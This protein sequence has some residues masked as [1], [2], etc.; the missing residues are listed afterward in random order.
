MTPYT[1]IASRA[2]LFLL[3]AASS[4]ALTTN[5]AAAQTKDDQ[6]A[7]M[8]LNSAH[9]AFNEKN[10]SFAATRFREFLSRYGGR[11][12]A[13]SARYGLALALLDSPERKFDE[14]RN[15]L[16]G[17][18]NDNN[19]P[20]RHLARYYLAVAVRSQGLH[21]LN[22]GEARPNEM[23]QRRA[24]AQ[25]RF[26]EA[27]PLFTAALTGF[28]D[29]AKNEKVEGK[30]LPVAVEWTARAR[31]DLAEMQVRLNRAKD[32][33][34]TAEPFVKDAVASR[35]RYRDLGR[36][37]HGYA[38]LLLKDYPA[39]EKSLTLLAPFRPSSFASHARY[40]LA[41]TYHLQDERT[42]ALALYD[43][44]VNEYQKSKDE[45]VKRL[46]QPNALKDNPA[47]RFRLEALVRNPPPEYVGRSQF[48]LGVLQ[49]EA[50]KFA[51]ARARFQEML[52]QHPQ[53]PLRTEAELR[54]GFCQV[55]QK[56]YAEAQKTLQPLIDRD[57]RLSDQVLFWLARAQAGAAPDEVVNAAGHRQAI[58]NAM[59]TLRQA[60]DRAQRIESQDP[61]ARA[62][63]AEIMFELADQMQAVKQHREA[64]NLYGQLQNDKAL[65]DR[66]EELAQ[67]Q[68]AALHLA[69][70]H[71]ASDQACERFFKQF[72]Q[73]TLTPAVQFTYGENSFF[74]IAEAEKIGNADERTKQIA[75]RAKETI[76]RFE[77]LIT[78]YPEDPRVHIARYSVGLTYYR[79][80]DLEHA[81][82]Y[83]AEIPDAERAGTLRLVPYLLADCTLR[84]VPTSIP[85]DALGAGKMEEQLKSAATLLGA[86]I[87]AQPKAAETPDALLKL[88]LT[89]QRLAALLAQPPDKAKALTEARTTYE[90]ITR[91]YGSHPSAAQAVLERAKCIAQ[92]GDINQ[93]TNELRRF[94][95][96][97]LR[98]APVAPIALIQLATYLRMQ[99]RA[100][101][102]AELMGKTRVQYEGRLAGVPEYAHWVPLMHYHYGICQQ[103][104]GK[105]PEA[106]AAFRLVVNRTKG[107]P[108][109]TEAAL[110]YGQCLKVEGQQ[111]LEKANK[112]RSSGKKE[113]RAQASGF[114]D[115]GTRQLREATT[116]LEGQAA[117]LKG[118]EGR[119]DVR[120]RMLYEA[121][122]ASRM[123]GEMEMK[124]ERAK[125]AQELAKK[126][127]PAAAKFPLPP[128]PRAKVPVQPA[129]K[130]ALDLYNMLVGEFGEQ[131]IATEARFE[132]AE[133]LAQR[134]GHEPALKLL[135][136]VLDKE[137]SPEL[138]EKV[139]LRLGAVHAASGDLKAALAQFDAVAA[140][141]KSP[142][143][144]WAQYRAGE[145]LL[146]AE[147]PAEAIKRLQP[148]RDGPLQ[149]VPGVTDRALLRLGQAYAAL[150]NWDAS[151]QSLERLTG[152]FANSVWVDEGRYGIGWSLQQQ[153]N[154]DGAV[155]AYAQVTAH[156][157][158]EVAARAQLQIGL[159]RL[160]QKRYAEAANALM[161]VPYTYDYPELTAAALLE[162]S[163]AYTS[164]NQSNQAQ[165]A[166]NRLLR[167]F[168]DTPWA[169]AARERLGNLRA[170]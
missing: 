66:R 156:T 99:N 146:K 32:A 36:Y 101:D 21:E 72:P 124:A 149:N 11:K 165:R 132:L 80:G 93:A 130:K 19:F 103:A 98:D 95:T 159:C 38:C 45:A 104:A 106:R 123:V 68:A 15:L 150:E 138:T 121:A 12:E 136:E 53:T 33:R 116:Y 155:N 35:S 140:N 142:L 73:S 58:T 41:R 42:E 40:L 22:E 119:Q 9:K 71:N 7:A 4:F 44:A 17:L 74:R 108:E 151:R 18:A 69:G 25:R 94:Q 37:L 6:A 87:A 120:A 114:D 13:A 102:A 161:V 77:K 144:G 118:Q 160:E 65:H 92:A 96:P 10:Y 105:F 135:N 89:Q 64:A 62:R 83:L 88:G 110:R 168:P 1:S 67:R 84:E 30:E 47:E 3:V 147:K 111:K 122:W 153:K 60:S 90:R 52:K 27:L 167:D 97:P 24:S 85:E 125:L 109:A 50:G 23:P 107:R 20:N 117:Q 59:N 148:F 131:A 134:G 39:A 126:L 127:G 152:A 70:D 170:N 48:Y 81:K 2:L 63:R 145:A 54:I 16:Q 137:P 57:Q 76:E 55:Q 133:L 154:Y 28:T 129:E 162:A 113:E 31:C 163:R 100:A 143:I 75:K 78:K 14:A 29:R 157:A 86:F 46:K 61:E 112:L 51:E 34:S 43:A 166:L 56:E 169:E 26:E 82:K 79:Q 115:Q 49:Y 141:P 139:R 164:L 5:Q 91:E 8:L 158:A 128:V